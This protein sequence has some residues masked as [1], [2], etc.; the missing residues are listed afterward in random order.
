MDLRLLYTDRLAKLSLNAETNRAQ[1]HNVLPVFQIQGASLVSDAEYT[2]E[3]WLSP[4]GDE[5]A[6]CDFSVYLFILQLYKS[7]N[8]M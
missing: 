6:K 1:S 4:S 5:I 7:L 8:S 3:G 2:Q